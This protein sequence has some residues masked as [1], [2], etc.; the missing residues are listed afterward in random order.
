MAVPYTVAALGGDVEV[1]TLAGN[2]VLPIPPGVQS[3]QKMR[4]SGQGL[5][6]TSTGKPGDLYAR[7]KVTVPKDLSPREKELLEELARTRGVKVRA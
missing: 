1:K 4:I 2:R 3:G 6:G 5:P 7:V